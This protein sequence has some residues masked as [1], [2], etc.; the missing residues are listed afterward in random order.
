[1]L[2]S[3][4]LKLKEVSNVLDLRLMRA[5]RKAGRDSL[6][7]TTRLQAR[8]SVAAPVFFFFFAV[9]LITTRVSFALYIPNLG[10]CPSAFP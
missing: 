1:M 6:R 8:V 7:Q 9:S 10:T 3:S 5:I 4:S 2:E